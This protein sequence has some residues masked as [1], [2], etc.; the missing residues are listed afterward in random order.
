MKPNPAVMLFALLLNGGALVA[1][2]P[3][4]LSGRVVDAVSREPIASAQVSVGDEHRLTTEDGRFR[5]GPVQPGNLVLEVRAIGYAAQLRSL[6]LLPGQRVNVVFEL[7]ALVPEMESITVLASRELRIRGEELTARGGDLPTALNGW[8]GIVVSRTGHGN[9][10]IAQIRG[11]AADEV[12]V[13]VDGFALNDPFTGRAD[14][15]R[16]PLADVEAVAL[17][18]G[19]QGARAGNRAVGGVLEIS[20]RHFTRPEITVGLGTANSRKA[21]V[22]TG[23]ET[24]ALAVSFEALP[25][26]FGIDLPGGGAGDR[27]NAGGEIWSLNGRATLGLEWTVRGSLSD[28]GLPG[29]SVNPTPAARGNDRSLLVGA[30]AGNRSWLSSSLQWL[31][32]RAG[33]SAPPPGFLAYDNHTWG[34]GGSMELGTRR[35]MSIGVWTGE[36]SLRVDGRHDRFDGD[37]VRDH[38]SFSQAGAAVSASIA[39]TAGEAT[40]TVA[41]AARVDWFTGRTRP[42]PSGRIDGSWKRGSTGLTASI[43]NGVTVPALADLLFRDG[44]GVAINPDLRPERV[45]WEAQGGVTQSFSS[46]GIQGSLRLG[47]FYGEI[48]DMIL[49]TP[50]F[51]NIWSPG[52]FGVRRVGG[53]TDLE[54]RARNLLLSTSAVFSSVTYDIPDGSQVPY[55]PRFSASVHANWTPGLWRISAGWNHLGTR[56]SRNRGMNPLP[57]FDLFHLG[58]ERTLAFVSLAAEIRD[59]TNARP[60]YIA[61]FPTPGRTFHL[62]LTLVFP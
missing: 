40:W 48:E 54:V 18:R 37:A 50:N 28:R 22:A 21:R 31:D 6:S 58:V 27:T 26:E 35:P 47:G 43:G 39:Q 7:S 49:W 2:Q 45:I 33:D 60:V 25:D 8:Q 12:L 34:W 61:G 51:R 56:Y 29:T 3:A 62:S 10:A 16:I 44:V 5:T 13:L 15:S 4:I 36:Y 30:R 42:I 11:S 20:S 19:A 53:E 55:R 24:A 1:Q 32:T 59:I 52:N 38:A 57:P 17:L 46:A 9:E 14:L 41:P 23:G